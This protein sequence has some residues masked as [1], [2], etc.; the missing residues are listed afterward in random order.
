ME[1]KEGCSS[2]DK[3]EIENFLVAKNGPS[4]MDKKEEY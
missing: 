4:T 3:I 1:I 2:V